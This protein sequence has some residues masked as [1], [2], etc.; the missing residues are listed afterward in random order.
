MAE[1]SV[2]E[3]HFCHS[4]NLRKFGLRRN[5]SG[6]IQRWVCSDCHRTFS[7]NVGFVRMKHNPKAIT[8][9]LQLYFSGESLRNTQKA[10]RLLGVQVCHRTIWKW[11]QKYVG[12]M[13]R[14]VEQITPQVGETWRAD[15]LYAKVKGDMKSLFAMMDDDTRFWVAQQI[16]DSKYGADVRPLFA[17]AKERTG[18][19]PVTLITDGGRHFNEPFKQEFDSASHY[20]HHVKDVRPLTGR[21]H[22]NKMERLNGDMR[23]REKVMRGIKRIDSPIFLGLQIY[24]NFIRPHEGLNGQTPAD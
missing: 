9:A 14:Y 2:S 21:I 3:R 22:N 20:S 6:D 15:E 8:T 17:Q 13:H 16:A 23:D 1:V 24:H 12:L 4:R 10:L 7:V 19:V 11:I 5:R 18:K